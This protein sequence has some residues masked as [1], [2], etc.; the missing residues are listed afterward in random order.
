MKESFNFKE[1]YKRLSIAKSEILK[2]NSK[3]N[4]KSGIYFL[5]R[6][7]ENNF[8]YAYIG[9]AKNILTRIAQH[10]IDHKQHIDK[11]LH[12]RKLYNNNNLFGWEI[13]FLNFAENELD[14]KEQFYIKEFANK[15]YQLYNKTIGSQSIGKK[16][17]GEQKSGKGYYDGVKHGKTSVLKE[18]GIL[19]DKYLNVEIK[20]N[21][22][23]IKERKLQEFKDMIQEFKNDNI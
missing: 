5:T 19:F 18:I 17:L 2:H 22:T 12:I 4:E 3:I 15:G 6:V 23:K 10:L 1:Y 14:E 16:A 9:Q 13:D 7:D 21:Y 20:G 11:S 8:K